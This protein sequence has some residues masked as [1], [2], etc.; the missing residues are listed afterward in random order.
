[1]EEISVT[2]NASLQPTHSFVYKGKKFPFNMKLFKCFSQYFK[3]NKQQFANTTE[4]D[5]FND[6]NEKINLSESSI[7]D[8]INFCQS[9]EI[10]LN[11]DNSP[12]LH[13]LAKK[14]QV[15]SLIKLTTEF[16]FKHQKEI[17]ID[18]YILNQDE[19]DFDKAKYEE[20]I[21]KDF[22]NYINDDKLLLLPIPV[23]HRIMTKYYQKNSEQT[24]IE[25]NQSEITEFLFKCL[26]TFGREASVL[27]E[28]IDLS[29]SNDSIR[30]LLQYGDKFDFH[31]INSQHLKSIYQLESEIIEKM[32]KI[33][34]ENKEK[35]DQIKQKQDEI[36]KMIR[37]QEEKNKEKDDQIKQKQDEIERLIQQQNDQVGQKQSEMEAALLQKD[38]KIGQIQS[39]FESKLRVLNDQVRQLTERL[40][41]QSI[42]VEQLKGKFEEVEKNPLSLKCRFQSE[43]DPKGVIFALGESVSLSA[44]SDNDPR[45]PLSNIKKY[46]DKN[47]N[48]DE[49]E[50]QNDKIDESLI[51]SIAGDFNFS[52]D[53]NDQN[54][55]NQNVNI[56]EEEENQNPTEEEE[57]QIYDY[58][59]SSIAYEFHFGDD[60]NDQN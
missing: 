51:T 44:P 9:R 56:N 27:F 11:K 35:D 24:V 2:A 13:M 60:E 47:Q 30:R 10:T 59:I 52:D 22:L 57:E 23:L 7:N 8:F 3:I 21:S 34:N 40:E 42:L 36:E 20:I 31:F 46:D 45:Y 48:N 25:T 14:Y 6:Q 53:E 18:F 49:D 33:T 39:E 17:V 29:R 32:A 4:I 1:M 12:S 19:E 37:Q 28:H 50:N 58:L 38:E 26:D 43:S 16:I 54:N 41:Q 15:S 5:I 55:E